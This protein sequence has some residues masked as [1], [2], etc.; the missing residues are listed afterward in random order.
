[1]SRRRALVL[2]ALDIGTTNVKGESRV[3]VEGRLDQK[4]T[5]PSLS[6][7]FSGGMVRVERFEEAT[8]EVLREILAGLEIQAYLDDGVRPRLAIAE[9]G[10][11]FF[12][13]GAHG[14][15]IGGVLHTSQSPLGRRVMADPERWDLP[16]IQELTAKDS[17]VAAT[18]EMTSVMLIDWLDEEPALRERLTTVASAGG[19]LTSLLTGQRA[20]SM[21]ALG[22]EGVAD[23]NASDLSRRIL[24]LCGFDPL[25]FP[26][27][28]R[29]G[30]RVGRIKASEAERLGLPSSLTFYPQSH[31][32]CAAYEAATALTGLEFGVRTI[33]TG[34]ANGICAPTR[35]AMTDA[36][37]RA[38]IEQGYCFYPGLREGDRVSLTYH[39]DGEP[40]ESLI[41][42][43][44]PG[45]AR[46]DAYQALDQ[47]VYE[48]YIVRKEPI[49]STYLPCRLMSFPVNRFPQGRS[50][51]ES[52]RLLPGR[53]GPLSDR[54]ML[55]DSIAG[56][57]LFVR[58]GYEAHCRLLGEEPQ[59]RLVAYGGGHSKS[60]VEFQ[61]YADVLGKEI[62]VISGE[63]GIKG[64][65]LTALTE[66]E[67]AEIL[68]SLRR[69]TEITTYRPDPA[70]VAEFDRIHPRF[71]EH[72]RALYPHVR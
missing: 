66:E 17:G 72:L 48:A 25:W 43:L 29:C 22:R 30:Q 44:A 4:V 42:R 26:R 1:M 69:E 14:E 71:L 52:F 64:S 53:S 47:L 11:A 2:A 23:M 32:Q 59:E 60:I 6:L 27:V 40:E 7:G 31:D 10:E 65:M 61:M 62:Q 67:R 56:K 35:S 24:D 9:L 13:V 19:Y 46:A 58:A 51:A 68:P 8:R 50:F 12:A 5:S 21:S 70:R 55:R 37:I 33:L 39:L 15:A 57:I 28:A 36:V 41:E 18:D 34:T 38:I 20:T 45:R 49:E 63:T 3:Y 16:R 54:A